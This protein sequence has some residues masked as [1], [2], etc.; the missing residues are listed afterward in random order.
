MVSTISLLSIA[1][2]GG[3][4][5]IGSASSILCNGC[6]GSILS[7]GSVGSLLSIGSTF[8]LFGFFKLQTPGALI[9][10][11]MKW[12]GVNTQSEDMKHV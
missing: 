10:Q 1:S 5:S 9:A 2:A 6:T 4:L 12:N 11:I 7:I 8:S 3:V